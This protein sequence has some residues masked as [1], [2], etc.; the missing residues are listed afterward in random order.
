MK[1]QHEPMTEF[2]PPK[3][4]YVLGKMYVLELR[5]R[6]QLYAYIVPLT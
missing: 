3:A 4:A 6:R 5:L 1:E 2:L